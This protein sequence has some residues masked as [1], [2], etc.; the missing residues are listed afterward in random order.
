MFYIANILIEFVLTGKKTI[1]IKSI[2]S[3]PSLNISKTI[4]VPCPLVP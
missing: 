4:S 2:K 1:F 3:P